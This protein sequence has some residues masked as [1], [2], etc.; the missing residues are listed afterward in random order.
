MLNC[1][2]IPQ[3]SKQVRFAVDLR[4]PLSPREGN[5]LDPPASAYAPARPR[6]LFFNLNLNLNQ[7]RMKKMPLSSVIAPNL[8]PMDPNFAMC[9]Y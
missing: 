6:P 8:R 9:L 1:Q 7:I 3:T 4:M 2:P 5:S